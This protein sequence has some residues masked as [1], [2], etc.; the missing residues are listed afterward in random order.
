MDWNLK[1]PSL[2]LTEV[3]Q[4]TTFPNMETVDEGSSRYGVYRTKG[5]FSVDLKLGQV[6]NFGIESVMAKPKDT[7][8]AAG[9]SKMASSP[10]G[11][12]KRARA[13][14]NGNHV[15]TCLVDECKSDLSNCRDYHRRHK[16]CELHSKSPQVTIGGQKQRFCQQCSR[17]HSLEEFDEGKRSCRKRLDGHNR[18][19][20]KPQP[21]PLTRSSNFLSNYQVLFSGTQLLPFSSSHI[22]S[23]TAMVNPAWNGVVTSSADVRLQNQ[24]Q[25]VNFIE[26][27]DLFLGSS[28]TS[29][30]EGKQLAFL[31]GDHNQNTHH[32]H[33]L[34]RTSPYSESSEGL[35]SKMFFD[36]N[37]SLT[38]SVHESP[39]A[40]SL[41]SSPQV[42]NNPGNGLNQMVQP[43]SSSLMQP[44]GL[45]LH[46]NNNNSLESV[47]PVLD[48]NGSD[49]CSSMYNIGSSGS[50]GSDAPQ[51][52]PFQW[53]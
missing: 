19:R 43:H 38:S 39:C 48:P 29:Y 13:F 27:Q 7:Y 17:F 36:N 50:Q 41:L 10:S 12:S 28:P 34:L 14:N 11:S 25:Q 46:D 49:H 45:S 20:R 5:E 40:L 26:K 47:E 22:Y 42:H 16:V 51:L 35:R 18:R 44:L 52:F 8:A 31:Q 23:S 53:E 21:E 32:L 37:N 2:D 24:H 30:K 33:T 4:G 1:S 6:G 3:D 15:V 9:V